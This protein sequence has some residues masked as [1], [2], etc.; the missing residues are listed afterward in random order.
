MPRRVLER[1]HR[2]TLV[3]L[4]ALLAVIEVCSIRYSAPVPNIRRPPRRLVICQWSNIFITSIHT[5][6]KFRFSNLLAGS[7]VKILMEAQHMLHCIV[8][9]ELAKTNF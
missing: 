3:V 6:I 5:Y 9:A 2:P 7:K 8:K 4:L 1:S